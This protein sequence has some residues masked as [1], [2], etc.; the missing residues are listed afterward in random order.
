MDV[1]RLQDRISRGMGSAARVIGEE[2]DLFRPAGIV[3]PLAPANRIMRLPVALDGGYPGYRRPR[4]Y[5][6]SVRGTFDSVAVR[7]GDYLQGPRGVLFVAALPPLLRP[8]CVLTNVVVDVVRAGGQ[9][10]AGLN[11]YGGAVE[12]VI[13]TVLGGWP[14]QMLTEGSGKPGA[15]PVDGGQTGWSVALPPTPAAIMTSDLL[16]DPSG[17]RYVVRAAEQSELGWRL[18][19]RGTEV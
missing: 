9:A 15:L 7:V 5:E 6:R 19:V 1:G 17:R 2:Y 10:S 8:L 13:E 18:S 16:Q 11:G 14:A 12:E 3:G 4:G